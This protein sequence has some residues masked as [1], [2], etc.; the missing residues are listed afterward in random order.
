MKRAVKFAPIVMSLIALALVIEGVLE[1][2]HNPPKDEGWQAHLF[3][4]LM[5]VQLPIILTFIAM[6]WRSLKQNWP[7]LGTQVLCWLLALGALRVSG[8]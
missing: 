6:G 3:Q 4:I 8:L 2:G 1:F 5:V 7:V